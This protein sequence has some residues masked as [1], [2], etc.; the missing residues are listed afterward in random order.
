M[1]SAILLALSAFAAGACFIAAL[2]SLI[3]D[4]APSPVAPAC[5]CVLNLGIMALHIWGFS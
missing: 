2:V 5:A 3:D 1:A 4:S